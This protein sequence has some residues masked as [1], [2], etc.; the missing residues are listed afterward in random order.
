MAALSIDFV[1][2]FVREEDRNTRM[3]T[4]PIANL[5]TPAYGVWRNEFVLTFTCV[6]LFVKLRYL[7]IFIVS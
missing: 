6:L 7:S 5:S 1:E 2:I 3:V 4:C